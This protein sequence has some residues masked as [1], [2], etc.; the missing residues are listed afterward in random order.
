M[1]PTEVAADP[2]RL[3]RFEQEAR[4]VAALNHP[5]ILAIYDIGEKHACKSLVPLS[6]PPF[7]LDTCFK[8][9]RW[10]DLKVRIRRALLMPKDANPGPTR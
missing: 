9:P 10:P 4:A 2:D 1:L 6:T 5:H 7:G 8:D 3:G